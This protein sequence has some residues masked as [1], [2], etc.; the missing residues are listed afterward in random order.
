MQLPNALSRSPS[1]FSYLDKGLLKSLI[2]VAIPVTLQTVLFSSK[3]VIDV[4]M[5]GQLSEFD[6][7]AA[8]IATKAL[9]VL[10]ILLSGIATGGAMLA[11]QHFGANDEHGLKRSIGLTWLVSCA[12]T[13]VTLFLLLL[14]SP[15]VIGLA[16]QDVNIIALAKTYL[17]YA[18]PSLLFM[19][20]Q[21]S[22]AAGLRSIHQASTAT[23]FSAIGIILNIIFNWVLI[24]GLFGLPAL[25]IKGAAIGTTLAA[26]FESF[27]LFIFLKSRRHLLLINFRQLFSSL[28]ARHLRNFAHLT[29]PT[30]CNFL[31]WALGVFAYTAIMGSTGTQGLVVL[32]IISPIEAFSLST[33][34]GIANAS[35]VV[36][37]NNLGAKEFQRAY[38]QSIFF[39]FIALVCNAVVALLLYFNMSNTLSWFSA[40]TPDTLELAQS[41]YLILCFGI[42]VRSLPTIMVVGVLRSGGDVKFCL[43]QDL[44]TQWLLGIPIAAICALWLKLE[45]D[46]VFMVFFLE[47]IFKWFSCV[48]RFRTKKWM[49]HLVSES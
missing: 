48:Y 38:Y 3:G 42:V 28:Y 39:V 49:N 29:V 13:L 8:G 44:L 17:L 15:Y 40:L 1:I 10:T 11:A 4:I 25:G 45:P 33:L 32:T 23:L 18:A 41:F 2:S 26:A 34:T 7:A 5:L 47:A 9:F 16:S 27:A 19:A 6:V 24:F 31:L 14:F 43:Y 36:V 35:A 22:I 20:Y 37:G 12:L 46:I 21:S 30:T